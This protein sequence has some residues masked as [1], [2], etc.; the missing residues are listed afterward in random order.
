MS[1]I[2]KHLK[3]LRHVS[4]SNRAVKQSIALFNTEDEGYASLETSAL[5][6]QSVWRNFSE[7]L[8]FRT[9]DETLQPRV[10]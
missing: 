3:A 6:D 7:D 1:H 4:I 8:T 10:G 2:K 9:T 5:T